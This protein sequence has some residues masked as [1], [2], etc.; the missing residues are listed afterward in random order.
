MTLLDADIEEDDDD[1]TEFTQIDLDSEDDSALFE[2]EDSLLDIFGSVG[3]CCKN[4]LTKLTKGCEKGETEEDKNEVTQ[5][6]AS[7]LSIQFLN[8]LLPPSN[9]QF[10]LRDFASGE[11]A[12]TTVGSL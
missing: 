1:D 2:V 11:A 12:I 10:L 3:V 9:Y 4:I 6:D 8:G 5:E 7:T